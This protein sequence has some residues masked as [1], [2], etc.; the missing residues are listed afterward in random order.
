MMR[1]ARVRLA[2][3]EVRDTLVISLAVAGS[4]L[5]S[6]AAMAVWFGNSGIFLLLGVPAV[7]AWVAMGL[8][9]DLESDA[10]DDSGKGEVSGLSFEEFERLVEDV[11]RHA[12][13]GPASEPDEDLFEQLVRDALDELPDYLQVAL[14]DN[15]AVIVSD[16]GVKRRAYG[17]YHGGTVAYGG[18]RHT[19]FVYRDTLVRDF[20]DD[21]AELRRQVAIT[22]RHEV[23]HHLG[24]SE[25]HV[26]ELGL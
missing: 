13:S 24:A 3:V 12:A 11:E 21:P 7:A 2:A 6:T 14:A 26:G 17:Y 5:G 23:A 19:I 10:H 1:S 8:I 22:V 16:D 20:G 9:A 4:V 25:R 15:V 18:C